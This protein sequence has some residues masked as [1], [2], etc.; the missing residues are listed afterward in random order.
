LERELI[1]RLK[2]YLLE[3]DVSIA[4]TELRSQPVSILGAVGTPGVRQLE[5]PKT[6]VEMLSIAGGLSADAGPT[7]RI[8]RKLDQGR[9]PLPEATEDTAGRFS[10]V[11][12][13]VRP[14]LDAK[15]PEK[16]I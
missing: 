15:N 5:G 13:D 7:V 1:K 12:I 11:E 16:N 14:L 3:P 4:V 10:T 6:L 9:I 8:T 2:V